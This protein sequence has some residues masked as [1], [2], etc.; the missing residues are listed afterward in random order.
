MYVLQSD[1]LCFLLEAVLQSDTLCFLLEVVLQSD[2]LCFLL[3]AVFLC[4][5]IYIFAV[6]ATHFAG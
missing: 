2:T 4:P 3:E 6:E 1:T 5:L